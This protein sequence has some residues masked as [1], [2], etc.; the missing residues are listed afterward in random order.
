M[1]ERS[2]DQYEILRELG[3]GG[4]SV[5]YL[6]K[7]KANGRN[8]AMKVLLKDDNKTDSYEQEADHLRARTENLRAEAEVLQAPFI[9]EFLRT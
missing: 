6:V 7:D 4:T 3:R 1:N 9:P 8:Y 2:I 5:V